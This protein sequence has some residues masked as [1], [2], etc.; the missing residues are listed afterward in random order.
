MEFEDKPIGSE[1][2]ERPAEEEKKVEEQPAKAAAS[3]KR[4]KGAGFWVVL[5]LIILIVLAGGYLAYAK[6]GEQI[7]NKLF[8]PAPKDSSSESS[9]SSNTATTDDTTPV[10]TKVVD[11]GVTW[12]TPVKLADLG[13][14]S[15][16]PNFE[17]LGEYLGTTYYK[18]ATT[19]TGGEIIVAEVSSSGSG[20]FRFIKRNNQYYLISLNSSKVSSEAGY[21]TNGFTTDSSYFLKSLAPDKSITKSE[22]ELIYQEDGTITAESGFT[23]GAQIVDTAWGGL[24][25]ETGKAFDSSSGT[26]ST[27]RYFIKLND[28]TKAYYDPKPTFLKDDKT[29]TATFTDAA[30]AKLTFEKM[31]TNGCGFGASTFPLAAATA[32]GNKVQVAASTAGS[33]LYSFTLATDPLA[34]YAYSIYTTG[35]TTLK[36]ITTFLSDYGIVIWVDDYGNAII[37]TN[38]NYAPLAE[39]GKPVIYLYPETTTQVSVQV[40]ANITKS[41]PAY[42]NVWNVLATPSGMLTVAEK[43]YD[44]LFWEGIGWGKYPEISSGTVVETKNVAE[45]IKSDLTRIGL[46]EKEIADFSEFWLPKMP[47]SK[48]TRLTWFT[49]KEMDQLAPLKVSPKPDTS[50]RVFLDFAGLD[51]QESIA[52]QTLPHYNRNGFTLVEWGGLLRK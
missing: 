31:K 25:L 39:C 9:S 44:S 23:A 46:N 21:L 7:G 2:Q 34:K 16:D 17:G 35:Q 30:K 40:G 32:L 10:V 29:F 45:K 15:K 47:T 41:D 36:P 50:I 20:I 5:I 11:D 3:K 19:S 43:Q 37:Y 4:K 52:P 13:L 26:A 51:S 28:S 1:P 6:Y 14:F 42:Q 12:I 38:T 18:V 22:T 8:G 48:Y 24:Y 27:A 33:K 49:T